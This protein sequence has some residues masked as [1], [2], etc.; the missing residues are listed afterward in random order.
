MTQTTPDLKI[1]PGT[2]VQVRVI[3][4]TSNIKGIALA[5]FVEPEI[6]G[7]KYLDCPAFSF[8][9]E[10]ASGQKLLFDLGV[11]KDH[12]NL[13][14][15]IADRIANGGWKVTVK[16]GVREQLESHGVDG[17]DI[18]AIIWSH[19]HWDHTGAPSTF[20]KHTS[21]IVGPGFKD[22][23]TPGYPAKKDAPSLE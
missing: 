8:L 15:R 1:P 9:I 18:D 6:K 2:T 13:A 4:T 5:P 19:W 17:N 10:H 12:E 16:Q 22:N 14:P 7:H 11:R 23:F 21:L 3:D 20:E